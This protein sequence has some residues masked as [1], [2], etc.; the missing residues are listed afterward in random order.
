M[1]TGAG[2]IA[3]KYKDG[4][5]MGSDTLI[6]Y[7]KMKKFPN[8]QR[9]FQ[10]GTNTCVLTSG[11]FADTKF[12]MEDLRGLELEDMQAMDGVHVTGPKSLHAYLK[13]VMYGKRNRFEPALCTLTVG[14]K[15]KGHEPYLGWVDSV[16]SFASADCFASGLAHHFCMPILC[17]A[18]D[19]G[20]WRDLTKE[21]AADIIKD[22]LAVMHTR[23]CSTISRVQITNCTEAGCT[24]EE[25][26]VIDTP[27]RGALIE[28]DYL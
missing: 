18:T 3:L 11:L 5:L 23:D 6:S 14:G 12:L 7:G 15:E 16:G 22:C 20:K 21:Q 9:A 26:F 8:T 2:V 24:T 13:L 4:V 17:E 28:Q 27:M 1:C 25:P 10:I 19:D